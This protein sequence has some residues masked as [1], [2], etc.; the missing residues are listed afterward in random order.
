MSYAIVCARTIVFRGVALYAGAQLS[1][2]TAPFTYF[3]AHGISDSVLI[4]AVDGG[5]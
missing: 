5:Q 1:G 4:T 2:R 3:A